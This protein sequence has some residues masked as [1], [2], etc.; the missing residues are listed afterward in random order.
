MK[1]LILLLGAI[2]LFG[3]VKFTLDA[4]V[5]RMAEA[6]KTFEGWFEGSRS[7]RN[8]NPG[9]LK[10]AGQPGA[11]GADD[12]G[13][14][15]FTDYDAGWE[16]LKSQIRIAFLGTSRCYSPMD[17]LYSFFEKYAEENSRQY[18]EFVAGE[19]GVDPNTTLG[20]LLI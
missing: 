7:Q 9:N 2:M 3:S 19:L 17:T 5:G 15:V 13:H 11:V 12:T 20:G 14:A 16:A 1:F 18:A 8:N 10:F 4:V 6:I